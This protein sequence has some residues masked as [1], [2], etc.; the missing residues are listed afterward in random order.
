MPFGEQVAFEPLEA[1]DDLVLEAAHL[2]EVARA[3]AEV[4]AQAVLDVSRQ[5]R[6][7]L[8]RRLRER[9]ERLARPLQRGVDGRRLDSSLRS[10]LEPFL[11]PLEGFVHAA[12]I[13][14]RSDEDSRARL[15]P[16]AGADRPA[17]CRTP[18]RI[19]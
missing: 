9:L 4:L 13:T 12:T 16:A 8:C 15:R 10:L 19:A 2:G 1:A 7:Q 5:A 3:R 6:L 14:P 18:R 17:S 11:C